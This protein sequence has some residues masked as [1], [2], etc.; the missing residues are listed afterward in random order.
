VYVSA[1]E[2]RTPILASPFQHVDDFPHLL[3]LQQ[4]SHQLRPRIFPDILALPSRQQHLGFD[5]N[6]SR[7][8]FQIVR[9]FVQLER[10]NPRQELFRDARD[11]NVV[12]VDLLISNQRE[13]QVERARILG[14]LHDENFGRRGIGDRQ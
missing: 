3:I 6:E 5:A 2:T 9:G 14:Q 13:Q 1:R 7:C 8:H 11:W 4:T 12:N 10:R